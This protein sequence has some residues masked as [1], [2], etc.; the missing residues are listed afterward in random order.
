MISTVRTGRGD[1]DDSTNLGFLS[2][3]KLMNTAISRAADFV[4]VVGDP[5]AMCTVGGC[6]KLW[7]D[8]INV[9]SRG[10]GLFP[11]T[12]TMDWIHLQLQQFDGSTRS[13]WND[14]DDISPDE[15]LEELAKQA[16]G[17]PSSSLT[18]APVPFTIE[19]DE[20]YGVLSVAE[21]GNSDVSH[22]QEKSVDDLL[23]DRDALL[24]L[25]K[26]QPDKYIRGKLYI[27]SQ[28]N[29]HANFID[30]PVRRDMAQK[31]IERVDINGRAHCERAFHLDEVAVEL[32][33][34]DS[35]RATGKVLGVLRE[36]VSR[37]NLTIVCV[38]DRNTCT[39]GIVRPLDE[40]LPCFRTLADKKD[41]DN[42][43]RRGLIAVYSFRGSQPEFCRLADI[44]PNRPNNALLKV[45]YLKWKQDS[46][47]PLGVVVDEIPAGRDFDSALR[48]LAVDCQIR[49]RFPAK[50]LAEV[51]DAVRHHSIGSLSGQFKDFSDVRVFTVDGE[52]A[53]DL[54]DAVSLV[55]LDDET[56]LVGIH[57]A[58]VS[59]FIEKGSCV[60]NEAFERLETFYRDDVDDPLVPMLPHRLSTDL[61]SLQPDC[62]RPAVSFWYKVKLSTG[63]IVKFSV[64]RSEVKSC[65]R[66]TYQEVNDIL[67]KTPASRFDGA[68]TKLFGIT[69][70]WSKHRRTS[71]VTARDMIKEL[72]IQV[73]G[74]A[75]S[76]VMSRF[77]DSVPLYMN[78]TTLCMEY[79][80]N[81]GTSEVVPDHFVQ[82]DSNKSFLLLKPVWWKIMKEVVSGR[83][84]DVRSLL[85]DAD[86]HGQEL[87]HQLDWSEDDSQKIYRCS[88]SVDSGTSEKPYVRV[89]SPMR[90]YMDLVSL[91]ILIAA[92]EGQADCPYTREEMESLCQ[93]AN[94]GL[95]Q[96]N[97][98]EHGI[99]VLRRAVELKNKA[100]V[101]FPYVSS[102]SESCLSLRFPSVVSS[103]QEIQDLR[104]GGLDLVQ[105]PVIQTSVMLNWQQRIYDLQ[106]HNVVRASANPGRAVA[107]PNGNDR[108]CF[109]LPTKLW[110]SVIEKAQ[111]SNAQEL[112]HT[113][114]CIHNEYIFRQMTQADSLNDTAVTT[115]T[116]NSPDEDFREHY[117]RMSL[118]MRA[119]SLTQVQ[120]TAD[121]ING[122]L[123]PTVQL[124]CLTPKLDICVEHR[125][126]ALKCFSI[127]FA[128]PA[129]RR[130]YRNVEAYQQA[131][132]PVVSM[133]AANSAVEEGGASICGARIKWWKVAGQIHGRIQLEKEYCKRRQLSFYPMNARYFQEDYKLL[134]EEKKPGIFRGPNEFDYL[135]IRYT[136]STNDELQCMFSGKFPID[137]PQIRT[138]DEPS[139]RKTYAEVV[140]MPAPKGVSAYRCKR[141]PRPLTWESPSWVGHGITEYISKFSRKN[142]S[143]LTGSTKMIN[144]HF[145]LHQHSSDFPQILL[146]KGLYIDCTIEWLPKLTPQQ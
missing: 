137:K 4:A 144:V 77:S 129:S 45:R 71:C 86:R 23:C 75:A 82:M 19:T 8:Y 109:S 9:C 44:N 16:A 40:S 120:L 91:R 100:A 5:V 89:T 42:V 97:K 47:Y 65:R 123:Q 98:Y 136:G 81:H 140:K 15:I 38:P 34:C 79:V 37:K 13:R 142:Q 70:A 83:F 27:V 31:G 64:F 30:E 49:Q 96:K 39:Q 110:N 18:A 138:C 99:R 88:A 57:I 46:R 14:S 54:D 1:V 104:Y 63:E 73:N 125:L 52:K 116:F 90:R 106:H 26:E 20:G 2:D 94:D 118:G 115:E 33:E 66:F 128:E 22:S 93:H 43:K 78:Q 80:H 61:C 112:D 68:L 25:I 132:L 133:E 105:T 145:R 62:L 134:P 32:L 119:G 58:D 117:V 50:A 141:K 121:V 92:I 101:M 85:L 72:M 24:G 143:P 87:W 55:T 103:R 67:N 21:C 102:F 17:I 126:E 53:E 60:D 84:T 7:Y 12:V 111:F 122:M 108:Y 56:C 124:F 114:K 74:T 146:T 29:I 127:E 6:R 95:L 76:L 135:C 11:A 10:G 3:P 69:R 35:G 59:Y 48:L 36:C 107:L 113:L 51:D 130:I 131:W 139:R 41:H 28:N